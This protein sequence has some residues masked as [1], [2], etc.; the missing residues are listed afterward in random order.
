MYRYVLVSKQIMG[1]KNLSF[2]RFQNAEFDPCLT[3]VSTSKFSPI[4]STLGMAGLPD[5][6]CVR[7]LDFSENRFEV[8]GALILFQSLVRIAVGISQCLIPLKFL[9]SETGI[10][11]ELIEGF[12][13]EYRATVCRCAQIRIRVQ[14]VLKNSK[15]RFADRAS[16]SGKNDLG[17]LALQNETMSYYGHPMDQ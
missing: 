11:L 3:G 6:S 2:Q 10:L 16:P 9:F 5:L 15:C 12:F 4:A 1:Q 17:L 8:R 14:D 13:D 7:T